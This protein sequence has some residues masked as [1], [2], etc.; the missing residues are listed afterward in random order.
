MS[1]KKAAGSVAADAATPKALEGLFVAGAKDQAAVLA[2]IASSG[3]SAAGPLFVALKAALENKK[4]A[5][6]REAGCVLV[7]LI[8]EAF[9]Q[10]VEPYTASVLSNLI[11]LG[12]DPK[13][14]ALRAAAE[15]AVRAVVARLSPFGVANT[16]PVIYDRILPKEKWQTR[17]LAFSVFAELAT[18]HPGQVALVLPE[19]IPKIT[20]QAGDARS[21]V[22]KAAEAS[23]EKACFTVQNKDLAPFIPALVS[24]L[25]HPEQVPECVHK[26]SSTTFV[27][28]VEPPTLAVVVPVLERGLR[29]RAVAV[30]RRAAVITENLCKLVEKPI[31]AKP[32]LPTLLPLLENAKTSTSDPEVR[33]V[34]SKAYITLCR[35]A[36]E[37][38]TFVVTENKDSATA[39]AA[40]EE[41]LDAAFLH[42][43][44]EL[45]LADI[46]PGS[47]F[48][49]K[50]AFGGVAIAYAAALA[51]AAC[52][53]NEFTPET[54]TR[55]VVAPYI[56]PFVGAEAAATA[57]ERL[58]AAQAR[59]A[60]PE[61]AAIDDDEGEDLCDCEFSL[62]YGGKILL[63]QARLHLKRGHRYGLCGGNGCGKSTLMRAIAN[64]Q[65]EGF[66]PKEVLPTA[67]VEHDLD[68]SL[69]DLTVQDYLIA[70]LQKEGIET[71]LEAGK[72]QLGEVGFTPAMQTAPIASLS[73]GWK[74]KLAL[75]RALL[76]KPSILLLD[77]PTN[78]LDIANVAWLVNYLTTQCTNVSCMIVS[79]DSKFLDNVCTDIIHYESFKLKRYRGNLSAF[80]KVKPEAAAYYSLDASQYKFKLPDPGFLE[81][82]S[83]KGKAILKGVGINFAYP[84]RDVNV[85]ND[86]SVVCSLS[87]RVGVLG[88]NGA[89]KSTLIKILTG[90]MNPGSGSVWKHPNV[91]IAYVAQH[92]FHHLEEHLDKTPSE[93][94]QWR[95]AS[96]DD[97]E[98]QDKATRQI[99]EDEEKALAA[100]VQIDGAK[101][102]VEQ[103]LNRRKFKSTMEYETSFVGM[104]PDKNKWLPRKWLEERGYGKLA[105]QVDARE[106]AAAGL[107]A[108]PLTSANIARHLSE[109][110]L[111]SEFTHHH[112]MR[113]LSGGQKVKVVIGSAC[114]MRPHL[115]VLDEP[116][117][118]LDR[119]SL[120]AL[121]GAIR[122]FGGG[123]VIISHAREFVDAVCQEKWTVGGGVVTIE[124]ETWSI[125]QAKIKASEQADEVIDAAGNVVKVKKPL[126]EIE[127]K[128][129]AKEKAKRKKEKEKARKK[130]EVV[131]SDSEDEEM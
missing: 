44:L 54:W 46:A 103:V 68:G 9:G 127:K 102:V 119:D 59:V 76:Q 112:R 55:S 2:G 58:R 93:Y 71:S 36:G 28:A 47:E 118:Y 123:V 74:M 57:T 23:I 131:S 65:V 25:A 109:V 79:H 41:R 126:T 7:P 101:F 48:L 69:S 1:S 37:S 130:G 35:A 92:A 72:K 67:V 21:E 120:G 3:V 83:T 26:L 117:N 52:H 80:V 106:A 10:A 11:E 56:A 128:R 63:N 62:A 16:L 95:F 19:V 91:R 122:D 104:T 49:A 121:A 61:E 111:E 88:P 40:V 53:G 100:A 90:E 116:T 6:A 15:A 5:A 14:P 75:C 64:G 89:G 66:P 105:D 77:E 4:D 32:L 31:Y 96:G 30:R 22:A 114:W 124:G 39:K 29:E 24:C 110:G 34:C 27:Q 115:I 129:I 84:G 43:E 17:V 125:N 113:G 18:L 70:A 20:A 45:I 99:S 8:C 60:N 73:G 82:V 81:G 86:V 108:V 51:E 87:S 13:T 33:E 50:E 78:H 85:L 42:N 107:H 12:G 38:E 94:I 98:A 97:K